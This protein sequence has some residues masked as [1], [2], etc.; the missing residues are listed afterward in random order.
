MHPLESQPKGLY[1]EDKTA[2]HAKGLIN[3]IMGCVYF[4]KQLLYWK[5]L[6]YVQDDESHV[7]SF[8]NRVGKKWLV[9][10]L[11]FFVEANISTK[12]CKQLLK[13]GD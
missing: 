2:K 1:E 8:T 11:S 12:I 6:R 13:P 9:V 5:S 4:C 3:S 7:L 10:N